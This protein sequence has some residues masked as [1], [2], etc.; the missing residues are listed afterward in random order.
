MVIKMTVD[1]LAL[2]HRLSPGLP[3]LFIEI[4]AFGICC[5]VYS[6]ENHQKN[7]TKAILNMFGRFNKQ[8]RLV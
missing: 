8:T 4:I 6:L 7:M 2:R 1:P 5:V 3:N